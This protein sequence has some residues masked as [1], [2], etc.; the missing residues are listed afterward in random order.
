MISLVGRDKNLPAN[1]GDT[2]SI[3]SLGK[4][5]HALEQLCPWATTTETHAPHGLRSAAR[6]TTPRETT[7]RETR[8]PQWGGAP[9]C[10]NYRESPRAET[11]TQS[12]QKSNKILKR[13]SEKN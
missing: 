8:A 7:P 11:K 10:C 4:I 2:G 3:P 6:E 5:L 13:H 9:A 12:N 1:A